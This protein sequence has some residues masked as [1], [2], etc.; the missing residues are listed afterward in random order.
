MANRYWVGNG[1]S[2]TDT[3]HWSTTSGGSGGAS[4]P[5]E[6]DNVF[7]DGFSFFLASQTVTIP[8]SVGAWTY[9][10]TVTSDD[11]FTLHIGNTSYLAMT[12]HININD[13][14]TFTRSGD[15]FIAPY[16]PGR[17]VN[18]NWNGAASAA[19]VVFQTTIGGVFNLQSNFVFGGSG[20]SEFELSGGTLNSNGYSITAYNFQL[21]GGTANLSG[22]TINATLFEVTNP[23][24]LNSAPAIVNLSKNVALAQN[25]FF[26][27]EGHTYPQVNFLTGDFAYFLG[28]N[29]FTNLSVASGIPTIYFQS[30]FTQTFV[31]N[32]QI[33]GTVGNVRQIR[34]STN[35]ATHT[36]TKTSGNVAL[37]YMDIK[38][39]IATG[40]AGWWAGDNSV[41]SGNNTGWNFED[42]VYTLDYETTVNGGG[43][44][45]IVFES[46]TYDGIVSTVNGQSIG[47]YLTEY[48]PLP[49][50]DYEYRVFDSDGDYIGVWQ[51]VFSDFGFQHAINQAPGELV[52]ELARS[53]ENR[54]VKLEQLQDQNG[55]PILDEDSNTILVQT[56]TVNSVGEGTDVD[57]NYNVDVYAFYGG[58][59]ALLDH[60]GAPILDH[61]SQQIFVQYGNPNGRRVYSGYIA[62]Y[63]L[64]FGQRTGVKVLVVSHATEL[65]HH[66]YKTAG[67][68]TTV[69]HLSVDPVAM[70]R[71]ALD[72]YI[73]EGGV[74]DYTTSTVPLSGTTSSYEF[75][76]QRTKE[77]GD[78]V[79]ELLPEG[80][81]H[82]VDPGE[83][84]AYMLPKGE[85]A[86]HT[87]YYEKHLTELKLRRSITQLINQVYVVGG[88][89]GSSDLF[90]YVEDAT[91][92]SNYRPGVEI[93]SDSRIKVQVAAQA[94]A[95]RKINELGIPRWRTS[96]TI[97]DA[98]YDIESIRL[99]QMVAFKNFGNYVDDLLLQIV[100]KSTEKHKVKLD[101]DMIVPGEAKR[102][103]EI[104]RNI[105]S[106]AIKEVPSSPS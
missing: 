51:D 41:N 97:T 85:E 52:V 78:K 8:D 92:V 84:L 25:S 11:A 95:Q 88:D 76:V 94:L 58:Y 38:D 24:V 53:P 4:V 65:N 57:M 100:N 71:D 101:L 54:V 105:L 74:I 90:E 42:V 21:V 75:K 61:N 46:A 2:W 80:Y 79:I 20:F 30:G 69:S 63:E 66:I 23:G 83:N 17:T 39:S 64:T 102:L 103:E 10:F 9:D 37:D 59:E 47:V 77:V 48:Q 60:N 44:G 104:K 87:F 32:P 14:V 34:S 16:S 19:P 22:S 31:N 27:G 3:A 26:E 56:E 45:E 89:T 81:Y 70:Y 36:L 12:N 33:T 96:I 67:G 62:D 99:G 1:G 93:I 15:G 7:F 68:L 5:L 91:S 43:E 35:G 86:D 29:T 82:F 18:V 50:K 98:V 55:D 13:K 106:E 6:T 49:Q 28:N 40:G 72:R 73:T